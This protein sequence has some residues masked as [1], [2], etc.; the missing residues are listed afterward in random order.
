VFFQKISRAL[1]SC[2][3]CWRGRGSKRPIKFKQMYN[4]MKRNWN[5]NGGVWGAVV[6]EKSLSRGRLIWIFSE[7]AQFHF[8]TRIFLL[9]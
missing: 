1:S 9:Q 7:T 4:Y 8:E 2:P 3:Y 5:F 6:S